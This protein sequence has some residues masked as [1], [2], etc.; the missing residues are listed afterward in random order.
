MDLS[1]EEWRDIP[2]F[3]GYY[4]ANINGQ[5]RSVDRLVQHCKGKN[6]YR[7]VKGR[8]L[9][10]QENKQTKYYMVMLSVNGNPKGYTVHSLI[11]AAFLGPIPENKVI[12]H[13]DGNRQNNNITNLR[14]VSSKENANNPNTKGNMHSWKAG[15]RPWNKGKRHTTET[16]EKMKAAQIK[17]K[18][19]QY[20]HL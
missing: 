6:G 2:G 17:R 3:E 20:P 11:T 18:N 13:I 14:Y 10:P 16:I 4:Q 19:D 7:L 5:V 12:D 8:I 1:R 15:H 9:K